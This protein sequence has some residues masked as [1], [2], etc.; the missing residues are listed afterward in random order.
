MLYQAPKAKTS[1]VMDMNT[2]ST[3]TAMLKTVLV[4]GTGRAANIN[5][6]SAGKT[7]TTDDSK[8]AC[9]IGYTPNVVTGVWVGN[10]DNTKNTNVTGGT[11]PALIWKDVMRVATEPYGAAEF[12]YPEVELK[13]NYSGKKLGEKAKEENTDATAEDT[14]NA[15]TEEVSPSDIT[16]PTP[17]QSTPAPVKQE[18]PSVLAPIPMATPVGIQNR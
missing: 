16:Q 6:P 18:S 13:G 7:G 3:L 9:F 14:E 2:A 15:D 8:D 10:D 4:S 1:K 5:K 11:V 12:E 17:K